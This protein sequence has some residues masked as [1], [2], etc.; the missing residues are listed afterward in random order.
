MQR[1][2][3]SGSSIL[4]LPTSHRMTK[5]LKAIHISNASISGSPIL[6]ISQKRESFLKLPTNV[7]QL[8]S[9]V[10]ILPTTLTD[11]RHA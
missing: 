11:W 3:T 10:I 9:H 4:K 2:W 8:C 5:A 6:G 1:V 7:K